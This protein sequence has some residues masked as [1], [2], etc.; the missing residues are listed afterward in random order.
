MSK[1][2]HK[3]IDVYAYYS[4]LQGFF[5][6]SNP[7]NLSSSI[8]FGE[9]LASEVDVCWLSP[10]QNTSNRWGMVGMGFSRL[11]T[12]FKYR[13]CLFLYHFSGLRLV[14]GSVQDIDPQFTIKIC[15]NG[16][17]GRFSDLLQADPKLPQMNLVNVS[18]CGTI[19]GG[20]LRTSTIFN[21]FSSIWASGFIIDRLSSTV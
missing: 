8:P 6:I 19:L 16:T 17:G 5:A 4:T 9:P 18:V 2:T 14:G 15:S 1:S 11:I 10:S 7:R 20:L 13:R 21:S 12:C 3:W